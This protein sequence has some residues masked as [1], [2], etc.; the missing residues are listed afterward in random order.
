[1]NF[2]FSGYLGLAMQRCVRLTYLNLS[3]IKMTTKM[4]AQLSLSIS[5]SKLQ[6]LIIHRAGFK[7]TCC[8]I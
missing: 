3:G 4:V 1:M 5:K 7:V 2:Q 8:I 6:T